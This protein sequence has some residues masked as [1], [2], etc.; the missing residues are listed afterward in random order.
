MVRIYE[1]EAQ[2]P[3]DDVRDLLNAGRP[4]L[5]IGTECKGLYARY[6][7][8]CVDRFKQRVIKLHEE[9]HKI[10]L[11]SQCTSVIGRDRNLQRIIF[12]RKQFS[13]NDEP[14]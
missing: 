8:I 5:A 4:K 14:N 2:G 12:N 1:F 10:N 9:I 7:R 13:A 3:V 11:L 6:C